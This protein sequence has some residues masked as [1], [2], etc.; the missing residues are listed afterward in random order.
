MVVEGDGGEVLVDLAVDSP[1]VYP[2]TVTLL[3]PTLA[4]LELA[5]RKLLA[6]FD[7]A[8]ARD[9]ADVYVLSGR[10]G[11]DVVLAAARAI[12][13]G[14]DGEVLAQMLATMARFTD[15]EIPLPAD[16]VAQG[17]GLLRSLERRPALT[18]RP[19]RLAVGGCDPAVVVRPT[20]RATCGEVGA[21]TRWAWTALRGHPRARPTPR[22]VRHG[23]R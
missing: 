2:P 10:F 23:G 1:P 14:F 3:G 13:A 19:A 6:L 7:R 9:F 17:E 22:R 4:P 16:M 15:D 11:R 18:T 21:A 20:D 5:D 8:A 12:D